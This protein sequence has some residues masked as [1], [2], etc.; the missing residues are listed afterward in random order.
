[1]LREFI[2]ELLDIGDQAAIEEAQ[3][4]IREFIRIGNAHFNDPILNIYGV[5]YGVDILAHAA[6][7]ADHPAW[8]PDL[9]KHQIRQTCVRFA[10][11]RD[12]RIA[13]TRRRAAW[14]RS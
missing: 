11:R 5:I 4:A 6:Q 10:E 14:Q 13:E 1:V 7:V 3:D 8:H 2:R 12:H 9:A